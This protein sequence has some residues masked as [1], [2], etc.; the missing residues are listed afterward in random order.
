MISVLYVD[1]ERDLIEVVQLFLEQAGDIRVTAVTSAREALSRDI[2]SFDAIVSDY[3]MPDMDGIALLKT[4]RQQ[5]EDIPF[6]LFTGRGREEVVIDAINNGADSYLQKGGDPE[7]QFAELAHRIHQAVKRRQAEQSLQES[8][9]RLA[10]IINFLPDAT[11][12]I[13]KSG[14][15]IAWNRAIEEMTGVMSADMLGKGGYEYAIPFYGTR[16]PILIDLIFEPDN[17]IRELYSHIIHEKGTLIAESTL[18][19]PRER[20]V[21]LMGKAGPLYNRQGEIIGAIESIRDITERK[22]SELELRESEGKFRGMAERISDIVLIVDRNF[23]LTYASPSFLKISGLNSADILGK[24]LLIEPLTPQEQELIR[25]AYEE[26]RNLKTTG[27]LEITYTMPERGKIVLEFH[28]V[29]IQE[30]GIFQGV[31]LLAHD[32]TSL[33]RTQDELR[34][35]YE[36]L[37]AAEEEL[38]GQYEEIA[39]SRQA[40]AESEEQYRTLFEG[41]YDAIFIADRTTFLNCNH[42]AEVLFGCP[43]EQILNR[44]Q[45]DFSPER[46]PDGRRSEEKAREMIDAALSGNPRFFEW[47][48]LHNDQTPFHAEVSLSRILI[49]GEYVIQSIVRDV[50]ERKKAD[51]ELRES[52]HK[53]AT[54]FRNSPVAHTLASAT[55]GKIVDVNEAFIRGTGYSREEAVGRT[56]DQLQ[57]FPDAVEREKLISL[58]LNHQEISGTEITCRSRSGEVK[59]CLI[60]ARAIRMMGKPL[61]LSTIEDITE[62]KRAEDALRESE[63]LFRAVSEYSHNALCL[64]N[65]QA[66]IVWANDQLLAL[67]GY[68]RDQVRCAESFAD[69]IAPESLEWV[70]ANFKKFVAGEPYEHHYRFSIIRADGEKRLCTKHMTDFCDRRGKRVLVISMLDITEQTKAE[71]ALKESE[72]KLRRIT[73]NAPDMIY[74][75]SLPDAKYEY[76][77]PASVALT[78]YHPQEFYENPGLFRSLVH[79]S[80]QEYFRMQWDALM[81]GNVPPNYEFQIIDR[82]GQVRWL[83]QRNMLVTDNNGLTIAIEGI[84]TDTTRQKNTEREL[85]RNELRSLAV[86]TNAGSWIWEIDPN[87]MYRYSSPAVLTIIGYKAEEIVGR[88]HFYDLFDPSVRED[89]KKQVFTTMEGREPFRNL[90]NLNVHKDGRQILLRTCGTPVFDEDGTFAGYCGVDE[91]I[92]EQRA[93]ETAFQAIVKSV[94]GTTGIASLWQ[95]AETVSSWLG[96]ECVMVGEIHPDRTSV[97]VLAMVLDGKRIEDFSYSLEG[98]P[99]EGVRGMGYCCYPDNAMTLFPNAKDIMELRIRSYVGTPLRDSEGNVFGILCALSRSPLRIVPSMQEIMDIIAV[100]AAAEIE[101][102]QMTRALLESEQKFRSLVEYA[103]EGIFITDMTGTILFANNAVAQMLEVSGGGQGLHGRNVMEFVAPESQPAVIHDY[104]EVAKGH[105]AYLAQ[106]K[107]ITDKKKEIYIESLGKVITYEG[108][109][110]DLISLHDITER[111]SAEDAL[112]RSQ[113]MLAEAMDLAH[114]ATWEYDVAKDL[115]TFDDRFYALYGTTAEQEGG[116]LMSSEVYAR[117]FV[118][119]DDRHIVGEEVARSLN[120]TNPD[121]FAQIEHRIIRR[122]GEIRYIVVR[123]RLDKDEEGRTVRTHGA[124][125]DITDIRKAEE[126]VRQSEARYRLLAENVHDVIFTATMDMHL[127]YISPS[128]MALRGFTAE[129]AMAESLFNA[130]SPA[131]FEVIT[132]SRETGL[133]NL[134]AGDTVLPSS[135]M[136]LEFYRKDGSTVWT[137]TIIALAFDNNKKPVGVVGV[138]RDITQR[139]QVENALLESEEKF[140]ALVET[141][142]GIIWEVDTMGRFVYISPMVEEI[143]GYDP[144]QLI[145]QP[146]KGLV[147][148]QL[149]ALVTR[150]L[151]TL[152]ISSSATLLPFEVVARHRDGHDLVM[153]IRPFRVTGVDGKVTGFRGVAIDTTRR[154]NAEEALKRANRQLNL[155]GSI[156]RHD[157]LNKITVIL[158]NL[159]IVERNCSRP[160][161]AEYLRKIRYATNAIKSQIEFTRI[162]QNLGT[163]EPQWIALDSVMPLPHVPPTVTLRTSVDTIEILAD[164]MLEK[165]FFNLIDNSIRHGE[166][167]TEIHVTT[168]PSGDDMVIVWEDNGTGIEQE[169]KERIFDRNFGRNTGLGMFLAREILSLT[170]I[171][172]RETGEPGRGARFEIAVPKG[173]YRTRAPDQ[174]SCD[175]HRP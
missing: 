131:S 116:S 2:G 159:K 82:A 70:L 77:S 143:L 142:P 12:A 121:Y 134:R 93:A 38:R 88:M 55:D 4:V 166:R 51:E 26:N 21:M 109:P 40:I 73:D 119:S 157:L 74:R 41:A 16:R 124:N 175:S 71:E 129:E 152:I 22:L 139:K 9:K 100:K 111:K 64:V 20:E 63:E 15:V 133:D 141:T 34:S 17:V 68:T 144:E 97:K 13:D 25:A 130:L 87:G 117:E 114:L 95:I 8:E 57:L 101:S 1:D 105:D 85:R 110:A 32:I 67:G 29:P 50:T 132:R 92:T 168:R 72:S 33:R 165:V 62:R 83:N 52:E 28:G 161:D 46:Q 173:A 78:G 39:K 120:T 86:N 14:H 54:V 80:W 137:E 81:A 115:F 30:G 69:F 154:K 174:D 118:H 163:H 167:V 42:S 104:A 18:P 19:R 43:R 170:N 49:R 151:A 158:G 150:T 138:I 169:E 65:E 47:V 156:T 146:F 113:Q 3:L 44:P 5:S 145:G 171:S 160:D 155:L 59:A 140:R 31:Q 123:I 96:T 27:P 84:I 91:D 7:V 75:M 162:Y 107:V 98:T 24:P 102:M 125:Q 127:T 89:L 90:E 149:Q 11:F 108:Q 128:V 94:V 6:I 58:L 76:I 10:D 35:A 122:D 79:P 23:C 45:R 147:I 48:H 61:I 126:A 53:F 136:E 99:C 164:P 172:I 135:T 37:A 66:K 106:Y 60:S 153:E 36:Q 103:L 112:N 148:E 56:A